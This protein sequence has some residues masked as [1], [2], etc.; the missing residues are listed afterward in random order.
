[1]VIINI[2]FCIKY[3]QEI[4]EIVEAVELPGV[5]VPEVVE[6]E[7]AVENNV[8][9]FTGKALPN[10]DIVVYI[11]SDQAVVYRTRSDDA[12][13]WM[14]NHS[15]DM[16]ELTPGEHSIFAVTVDA[17]AKVKSRPSEVRVFT[18]EKSFWVMLFNL[19]NLKTTILTLIIISITMYWL[20]ALQKRTATVL[21]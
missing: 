8:F 12:G 4:I 3:I 2:S 21:V 13:N 5:P 18:I 16:V 19:L 14:I 1:M 11:H 7:V 15:Q 17:D 6:T 9:S 20:Y 10:K